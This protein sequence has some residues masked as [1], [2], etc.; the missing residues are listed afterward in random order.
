L[1]FISETGDSI[2]EG[3]K[4]I[5]YKIG[6]TAA[7]S[8]MTFVMVG[9]NMLEDNLATS[10]DFFARDAQ[11]DPAITLLICNGKAKDVIKETKNL[12]LSAGVGLQKVFI[13]KQ[14]SLN[15]LVMP[16]EEF[17]NNAFSLSKSSMVSG[18]DITKEGE[19][20]TSSGNGSQ[21]QNQG[22]LSSGGGTSGSEQEKQA[23]I[24]YYNDVYYFK[25]GEYINKFD[26]EKSILG[27]F[28]ADLVSN[29]GD[30]KVKNVTTGVLNDATIGLQF[31]DKETKVK[32]DFKE[33]KPICNVKIKIKDVQITEILN[34]DKPSLSVYDSRDKE[35]LSGIEKEIKESIKDC[36]STA[37]MQAQEDNVDVFDFAE[38][39]Y[40]TKTKQWKKFYKEYGEN[41]LKEM[42]LK[43]DVDIRNIN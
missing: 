41:Y 5:T 3:I 9:E 10:L 11:V 24:K 39:A 43:V 36:I 31:S 1:D 26:D 21:T 13:Y 34:N 28:L 16:L 22:A 17:I 2:A 19:E 33:G 14:S 23:R 25:N 12:E 40:Q 30:F 7:L 32:I 35:I 18:I 42:K 8:H 29:S 4:K 15:G 37:F 20:K 38:K 27:V 6:K